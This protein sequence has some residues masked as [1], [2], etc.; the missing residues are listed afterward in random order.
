MFKSTSGNGQR[1]PLEA[2][3][4][5]GHGRKDVWTG[6][7]RLAGNY[8]GIP[9]P[10]PARRTAHTPRPAVAHKNSHSHYSSNNNGSDSESNDDECIQTFAANFDVAH[11]LRPAKGIFTVRE[12]SRSLGLMHY[13]FD[14][15]AKLL[16]TLTSE[17]NI[18]NPGRLYVTTPSPS[19]RSPLTKPQSAT[20]VGGC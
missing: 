20:H 18:R 15:W 6:P 14:D 10:P 17:N 11:F 4:N 12:I 16:E 9:P 2:L 13:P 3:N 8:Q 7:S 1:R 5:V 19:P